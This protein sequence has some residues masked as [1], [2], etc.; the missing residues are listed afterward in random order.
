MC[1]LKGLPF[2]TKVFEALLISYHVLN[3]LKNQHLFFTTFIFVVVTIVEGQSIVICIN[4]RAVYKTLAVTQ[5][6]KCMSSPGEVLD[7]KM[8][9]IS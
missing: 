9:F 1:P 4:S 8:A 7:I 5:M 3:I 2:I 6:E